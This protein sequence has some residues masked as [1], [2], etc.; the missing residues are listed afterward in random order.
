M[1]KM[2]FAAAFVAVLLLVG[3]FSSCMNDEEEVTLSNDCIITSLVLGKLNRT[4]TMKTADG[5]DSAYQV[6]VTGGYYPLH[7]DQIGG[8][9]YN[10]DSLPMGTDL[11]RV[12]F[13]AANASS[14]ITVLSLYSGQ[15]TTF[16]NTDSLD[17]TVGRVLTVHAT[18]GTS[19][20]SYLLTLCAHQQEP[21]SIHWNKFSHT[22]NALDGTTQFRALAV[23]DKLY[24]LTQQGEQT[25]LLQANVADLTQD[26][27]TS[28]WE[29]VNIEPS[30]L[31]TSV[32]RFNDAFYAVTTDQELMTSVEGVQWESVQTDFRPTTLICGG[33]KELIAF[34]NGE[35]YSSNNASEWRKN[36]TDEPQQLPN[37]YIMGTRI[38]S[39]KNPTFETFIAVGE[40]DGAHKVW[41]REVDLYYAEEYPWVFLPETSGS[42]YNFPN[43]KNYAFYDYDG[44]T[45]LCGED[46]S[47]KLA[48][49]AISYDNGRTWKTDV[50][51]KPQTTAHNWSAT[52]DKN[53]YIWL[54]SAET[55]EIWRGRINRLGWKTQPEVFEKNKQ[56]ENRANF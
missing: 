31:P 8:K 22:E 17:C 25:K 30:I 41:R 35:F 15:D 18:D 7:I 1:T 23:N 45:L 20:R 34:A 32:V 3:N 6:T 26:S 5:K 51:T 21:D 42:Y 40:K 54:I 33:T 38:A 48:N 52:V 13:S 14:S 24:L 19:K 53:N 47:G 11:S 36:E 28:P 50:I 44:G 10:T 27:E 16:V 9:I 43:V 49:L 2:R 39:A 12:V 55:G 37:G 56:K 46:E 4:L 29:I